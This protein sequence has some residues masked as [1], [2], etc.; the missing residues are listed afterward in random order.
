MRVRFVASG[1][2]ARRA[3]RI[4]EG[5]CGANVGV[6]GGLPGGDGT[7]VAALLQNSI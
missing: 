3:V 4:C 6:C 7:G 5:P 2:R 1:R